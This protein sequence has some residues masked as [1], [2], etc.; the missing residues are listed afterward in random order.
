MSSSVTIYF[1]GIISLWAWSS[2]VWLDCLANELQGSACLFPSVSPVHCGYRYTAPHCLYPG[3]GDLHSDP[4]ACVGGTTCIFLDP[5][6]DFQALLVKQ[7]CARL[8]QGYGRDQ[9]RSWKPEGGMY[10][11]RLLALTGMGR[12]RLETTLGDGL[13]V[14]CWD[15]WL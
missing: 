8:T 11:W 14:G 10:C 2:L 13:R 15:W 6:F 12:G 7:C 5:D 1:G 9:S 4:H 3:P